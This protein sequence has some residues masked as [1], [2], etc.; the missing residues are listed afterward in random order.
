MND[1]P[2]LKSADVGIAMGS[3]SEVTKQ[4]AD[5]VLTN[6]NFASI[7]EAIHE[8]RSIF[9]NIKKF[10]VHE[11]TSNIASLLLLVISLAFRDPEGYSI[12]PLSAL[13]T[14]WIN[15][16]I[17]ALPSL[18]LAREPEDPVCVCLLFSCCDC[19]VSLYNISV[20]SVFLF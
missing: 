7:V 14:I 18:A 2:A 5:I 3:G 16:L 4:T 6:D 1:A 11:I 13:Q 20:R 8:G 10:A 17:V 15:T 12:N 19:F 9:L